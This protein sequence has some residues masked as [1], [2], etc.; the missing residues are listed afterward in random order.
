M[1]KLLITGFEPFGGEEINPSWEAVKCLPDV[2]GEYSVT[3]LCIPVVFKEAAEKVIKAADKICADAIVC[4]GQAGGRDAIT[5]ELVGINLRHA[6]IPDNKGYKPEDERINVGG[7]AAYFSTLPVRKIADAISKEGIPSRVSY[8][9]GAYVCNDVLYTL[10]S[11]YKN[12]KTKI[13]FIHIPYSKEQNK[14]P[15]MDLSLMTKGLTAVIENI[16][17]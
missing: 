17:A 4:V 11:H 15:S 2:V 5:P 12:R 13:G 16:D 9:A 7:D 6:S 14:E 10:L 8:S 1:K 3:R